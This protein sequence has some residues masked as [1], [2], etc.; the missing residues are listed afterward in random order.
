MY[1][2]EYTVK[3]AVEGIA[4]ATGLDIEVVKELAKKMTA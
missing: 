1:N 4:Q 3:E 2:A